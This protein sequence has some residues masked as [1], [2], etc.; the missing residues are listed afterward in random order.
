MLW[1]AICLFWNCVSNEC[2]DVIYFLACMQSYLQLNTCSHICNCNYGRA[3][4]EYAHLNSSHLWWG[5]NPSLQRRDQTFYP[6]SHCDRW[7]VFVAGGHLNPAVTLAQVTIGQLPLIQ[8][9]VYWLAQYAGAFVAS[10]CVYG[11]LYGEW[12]FDAYTIRC[13]THILFYIVNIVLSYKK[14]HSVYTFTQ[15]FRFRNA[16][17]NDSQRAEKWP[18]LVWSRKLSHQGSRRDVDIFILIANENVRNSYP[19]PNSVI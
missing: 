10:A 2:I 4:E 19:P 17:R 13:N 9:P 3:N 11:I 12:S 7:T 18:I 8:L 16:N 15:T 6:L 14:F 5:S 1:A